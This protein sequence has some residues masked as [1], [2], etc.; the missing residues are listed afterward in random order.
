MS[1]PGPGSPVVR[2]TVPVPVAGSQKVA[3][4]AVSPLFG[5]V[6][7]GHRGTGGPGV[8]VRT[9]WPPPAVGKHGLSVWLEQQSWLIP[10]LAS[11]HSPPLLVATQAAPVHRAEQAPPPQLSSFAAPQGFGPLRVEVPVVRDSVMVRVP[12]GGGVG[13]QLDESEY[14]VPLI[15]TIPSVRHACPAR[16]PLSQVP[17]CP[18]ALPEQRGQTEVGEV[19]NTSVS[20]WALA[21]TAPLWMSAVAAVILGVVKRLTM[22]T[23]RLAAKS[24]TGEPSVAPL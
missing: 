18:R 24:G 5:Y 11:M 12:A 20:R 3:T 17:G 15:V 19:R 2:S 7:S 14:V 23:G 4:S 21:L 8:P 9:I 6:G 13:V 22:Q 16:S 10:P 1:A